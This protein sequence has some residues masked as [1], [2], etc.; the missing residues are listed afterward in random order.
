MK[1]TKQYIEENLLTKNNGLNSMKIKKLKETQ[2]ITNEDLYLI[3]NEI[4]KPLCICSKPRKFYNFKNGYRLTCGDKRCFNNHPERIRKIQENLPEDIGKRR[5]KGLRK[6]TQDEI[7]NATLKGKLTCLIKYNN[8]N[9][10]NMELLKETNLKRYGMEYFFQTKEFSKKSKSTK[11][12][13]YGNKN[14]NNPEK[15]IKTTRI[16][17]EAEGTMIPLSEYSDWEL[18]A[19][20][21]RRLTE[22]QPLH[23]LENYE[24]RGFV[25][26]KDAYHLDHI[27]SIYKGFQNNIPIHIIAD[28]SNLQMLPAIENIKKGKK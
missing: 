23:T 22:K 20:K 26:E 19:Y 25:T 5:S 9:Y 18:Y 2:D 11:L 21:V 28:I 3:F 14:Y 6:R 8:E 4:E 27:I 24:K 16:N 17:G 7:N 1:I 15:I 12:R 10:R 13:R